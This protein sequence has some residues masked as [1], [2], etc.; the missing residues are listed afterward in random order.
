MRYE[1]IKNT[2]RNMI[3]GAGEKLLSVLLPFLVRTRLIQ[4]MGLPYAGI[5][6]LFTSILQILSLAELGMGSAIIYSLYKPLAENDEDTVC[7]LM[8]Y[9]RGAYRVIGLITLGAGVLLIPSLPVFVNESLPDQIQLG[10][11]FLVYLLNASLGYFVFPE[12]KALLSATQHNDITSKVA[13]MI[14]ILGSICQLAILSWV[15]NYYLYIAMVPL[16]TLLDALFSAF[17]ARKMYPTYRCR[18]QIDSDRKKVLAEKMKGLFVHRICGSTR[19]ALDNIFISSFLGISAVGIY[20]NYFYVMSSVRNMLDVVTASMSAGV[21][22]SVAMESVEKNRKDLFTFSFIYEWICGWC[23][24]CLLNLYQPFMRLWMGE[25]RLLGMDAV[26]AFCIYFY[27]WTLGDMKSQ[28]ADAR[29]LWWK[30]RKRSMAEAL[31]NLLLN[32]LLVSAFGITGV[33]LATGISILFLGFPWGT[34]IL[35]KDYFGI[36]QFAAYLRQ[37]GLFAL[38]TLVNCLITWSVCSL[39]KDMSIGGLLLRAV[40]CLAIP[41]LFYVCCYARTNSFKSALPLVRSMLNRREAR[42]A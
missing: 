25:E 3:W 17:S 33:V 30:D 8:H 7:A 34:Y 21:G 13:I 26:I 22:N 38:V 2:R 1:R 6:G 19:N 24:V 31:C 42:K 29:G 41:N 15:P 32:W 16:C 12:C 11:V 27:V 18:G 10:V 20:G 37:E 28:Y 40:L 14:R 39:V 4:T 9:F 5:S 23:T 35:F 36:P